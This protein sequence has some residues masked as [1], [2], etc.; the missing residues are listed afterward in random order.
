MLQQGKLQ[1][2]LFFHLLSVFQLVPYKFS[3][4]NNKLSI[5]KFAFIFCPPL[6]GNTISLDADSKVIGVAVVCGPEV[7]IAVLHDD[8]TLLH[9]S[10]LVQP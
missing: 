5:R 6:F 4:V 3:V 9:Q 2:K 7:S 8:T 1:V 10:H